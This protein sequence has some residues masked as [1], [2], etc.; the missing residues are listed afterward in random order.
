[1]INKKKVYFMKNS[2]I[3]WKN[4]HICYTYKCTVLR[5]DEK[6]VNNCIKYTQSFKAVYNILILYSY[7]IY[8]KKLNYIY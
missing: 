8:F 5:N 3:I 2:S 1:M 4:I 6:D 7:E